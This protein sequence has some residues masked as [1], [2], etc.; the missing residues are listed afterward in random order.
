MFDFGRQN[1]RIVPTRPLGRRDVFFSLGQVL[2]TFVLLALFCAGWLVVASASA[3]SQ[4]RVPDEAQFQSFITGLWPDARAAGVSRATFDA[5]TGGLTPDA[6]VL[7]MIGKQ[8]EFVKPIWSYID[9]AVS[10]SRVG[11]GLARGAEVERTLARVEEHYGVDRYV[12]LAVWGMETNY[13][14]FSGKLGTIRSLATLAAAGHRGPFF[15]RELIVALQILEQGHVA[16]ENMLGSWAGAM[17]QTQFMPSSFMKHAVDWD[18]DGHKDIWSSVPDALAS[19]ANYLA[20]HGWIKGWTWGY[21]ITL[22]KHFS[23]RTHE[24]NEYRPFAHWAK[25][26]V[27]RADGVH[28]PEAGEGALLLPAG[29]NGPAFLVTR[30]FAAIKTYN[31]SNA[32][33]LGVSLLSDRL[34]GSPGLSAK[35]PVHERVLDADQSYE[36]QRQLA[37]RGYHIGDFDGKIGEKAQVAI[38]HYQRQAGLEPD[39]F[40]SV[41]LLER[42]RTKP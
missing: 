1:I 22:P 32:Y 34:A 5:A 26:G 21:E 36:L 15:R 41:P 16:P 24:P 12:V 25:A 42:M 10:K 40:A 38:R 33:A 9:D 3:R 14:G 31:A 37:R 35:W 2:R 29:R 8:A 18:G 19:T 27:K 30:N 20:E 28:M 23:L 39:G 17:G 11:R 7:R 13:G 4:E 6:A